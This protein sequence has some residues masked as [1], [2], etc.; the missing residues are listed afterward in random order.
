VS[1]STALRGE[2]PLTNPY[3]L[4]LEAAVSKDFPKVVLPTSPGACPEEAR[5]SEAS[6]GDL[7]PISTDV[8]I[9]VAS[10]AKSPGTPGVTIVVLPSSSSLLACCD[11]TGEGG[12]KYGREAN[13]GKLLTTPAAAFLRAGI[14]KVGGGIGKAL[15]HAKSLSNRPVSISSSSR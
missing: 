2:E 4:V 3:L 6:T 15:V 8:D 5:E 14:E 9:V 10:P 1:E 7:M 11:S 12:G 13:S